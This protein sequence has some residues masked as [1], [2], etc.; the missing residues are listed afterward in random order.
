VGVLYCL[1]VGKFVYKGLRK[2][3]FIPILRE[4]ISGTATVMLIIVSATVFGYYLNWENIPTMLLNAVSSFASN[5]FLVLL[6]MNIV[7]LIVGMF[8][9]GG[10]AL[11][12]LA[13]LMVPIVKAA[14]IDLV[15]FGIVCN[16][17]IMIDPAVRLDD[18]HLRVHHGLQDAGIYQ[19]VRAVYHRAAHCA[20]A[21]DVYPRYHDADTESHLLRET[22]A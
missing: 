10:A 8:L 21:A 20:A 4:T 19:R 13:P 16:V 22:I 7:L 15:H 2:E 11:I 18:V 17:N 12:I 3:H 9:E 5:K 14:G 6:V 1:I